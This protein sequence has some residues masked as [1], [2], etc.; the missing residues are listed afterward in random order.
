M[1]RELSSVEF[2]GSHVIADGAALIVHLGTGVCWAIFY[3]FF[4]WG[5][6]RLR[7]AVQGLLFSSIPAAFAILVVVPELAMMRV[8]AEVLTLDLAHFFAPLTVAT[9]ASLLVSH[10]IYGLTIGAIYRRPVGYAAD[11]KPAPPSP[12]RPS[13]SSARR[14]PNSARFMFATGIECSYPT[15]D[16]GRWRR[17][18]LDFH[19]SLP[20]VAARFR[21]RARDRHHAT[22]AT[23]RRFTS[24]FEGPGRYDWDYIDP[25]MEELRGV[26]SGAD[27]RPLPFRV[28]VMARQSPEP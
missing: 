8:T 27:R 2:R 25:Q 7:P 22:S 17:D 23:A 21:A 4:F 13:R 15:I 12:R 3:A 5:R 14:D 19:P 18:E 9:V 6:F 24:I 26:R 28:A 20:A 1:V 16:H 11:R 10:A